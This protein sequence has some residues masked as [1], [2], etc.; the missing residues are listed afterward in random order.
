MGKGKGGPCIPNIEALIAAGIDPKT[1]LPIK[2]SDGQIKH[3]IKILLRVLDEQEFVNR[4]VW[5]NIPAS[6]T[7]QELER[8]LYYKG[9][10]AMFYAPDVG[11][12]EFF[13]TPYALDGGIDFYGRYRSIK[14]VPF[15]SGVEDYDNLK[16]Y[17]QAVLTGLRL[18]CLYNPIDEPTSKD[19]KDY[20]VLLRD[21]TQQLSQTTL[22]RSQIQEAIIDTEAECIPYMRTNMLASCGIKA[23]RVPNADQVDSV[24]DVSKVIKE[25][26]LNGE[27]MVGIQGDLEF[28]NLFDG[29]VSKSSEF[30]LAMQ[31]LD[32]FRLR[33][34][35]IKSSGVFEKKSHTLDSEES[36]NEGISSLSIV[37]G[38]KIRKNFCNIVNS[39]WGIGIDV[40]IAQEV[41]AQENDEGTNINYISSSGSKGGSSDGNNDSRV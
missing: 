28:Q 1:G 17:N 7:S 9:Q 20:C 11:D 36:L 41:N 12:G 18:K 5:K 2:L 15:S 34:L 10:L 26:S 22:P 13:V 29:T 38:L 30:M 14:P 4:Y 39:L 19:K 25:R 16:I 35:G 3:S 27:T 31:S 8:M 23:I 33:L 37:D 40:E 21:Y 24:E 32:N 6:I